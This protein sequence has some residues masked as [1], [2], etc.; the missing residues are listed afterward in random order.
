MAVVYV[1]DL[2]KN[3]MDYCSRPL[4]FL[5]L[6]VEMMRMSLGLLVAALFCPAGFAGTLELTALSESGERLPCRVLVR[7]S[8]GFC[9]KPEGAVTLQTGEDLWFM[10]PGECRVD[11][12]A[13]NV[14]IRIE[15]GLEYVRIKEQFKLS[16][17]SNSK[18][19][20]LKRWINMKE[21][22][23][24]C[25]ENHLH[26]DSVQLAPMLAAEG[27]DFG[28]SL[29]W[30]RGP[31][32]RRPIPSGEGPIRVLQF[33]NRKIPTSI[34][35]AELEYAWGAAYIQNLPAPMPV[36]AEP[37]R[38]NL[39]YLWHAVD[40]GAIVHYQGGWSREVLL[41]ALL[42]CVH[43][44]NIC[45][46]NFALHRFQP[47][48][49]YSNLLKVEGF[50]VYPDTDTGMLRMNTD[51]YYRL[52]NCGLRLAAGAGSATGVKQAPVGYNRAY[53]RVNPEVLADEF[54]DFWSAGYNFVTNGPMVL[55]RTASDRE[56]GDTIKLPKGGGTIQFSVETVS[57]QSLT[58][59][60]LVA[61]GE[62]V[63]SFDVG[64]GKHVSGTHELSVTDGS[65]VAARCTARDEWLSDEELAAYRD[66]SGNTSFRVAPSR[67]RFAHTSPI[68]IKVDGRSVAETTSVM[69]GFQMLERFATFSQET[70]DALYKNRIADAVRTARE[71][72]ERLA[73]HRPD[74]PIASYTI[75][76]RGS[77]I[78]LDGSLDETA[79]KK[80]RAADAFQFP[81]WK[82][83][84]QEQTTAKLLWD[85]DNL[86]VSFRCD[87]AHAWAEHTE[88]DSAVYLDDCVEVFTAPDIVRPFN[89]FNIEM[90]VRRAFLDQHHP[91]GPGK[92]KTNWNAEGVRIATSVDGTINDDSDKDQ[93]WMLEAAIPFANFAFV[94]QHTPPHPG[95]VWRMNLNRLG[96]KTNPQFSQWSPSGT[97]HP[98]YHAPE[99]FGRVMFSDRPAGADGVR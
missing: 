74:T 23:Y 96:G 58:S 53:V 21:R 31:D 59:V 51:T 20:R 10:S 27:L 42:G 6:K 52:L 78:K 48:S 39:D 16:A 66:T 14:T 22:G 81:W 7:G 2:Y 37:G 72:L 19:Y 25:G 67:L 34:Y 87:D 90:N 15:R 61:N 69:E 62:V 98:Q 8:D 79:W 93:S 76:R 46:N 28:T 47:R 1:H 36:K 44:V 24:L 3:T 12:P 32:E 63:A 41:D 80:A 97:P 57:N 50:P 4:S 54:C 64:D 95:D 92:T 11:V 75:R 40:A 13:G 99:Y 35:D 68:Y 5:H 84:R 86:Y 18:T 73:T 30:W 85:D 33:A 9:V 89:Y 77:E 71:R 49:R 70:T 45:N 26:V 17:G 56:P 94:A 55:L 65:W 82:D 29:T 83:G 60:E 38:P 91:D 43:T 88:R